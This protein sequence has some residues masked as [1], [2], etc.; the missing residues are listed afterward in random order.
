MNC[1]CSMAGT[2]ACTT[3]PNRLVYVAPTWYW[4]QPN[5]NPLPTVPYPTIDMDELAKKVAELLKNKEE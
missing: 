5:P 4:Q 2:V 3:C 1:C